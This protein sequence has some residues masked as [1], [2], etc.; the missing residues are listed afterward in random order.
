MSNSFKIKKRK[1]I[2]L[3]FILADKGMSNVKLIDFYLF[4]FLCN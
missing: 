1:K 3:F 4:F 2:E